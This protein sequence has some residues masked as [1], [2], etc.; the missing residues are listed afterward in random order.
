M[1]VATLPTHP[2][3]IVSVDLNERI[4]CYPKQLR[5]LLETIAPY[6]DK[7]AYLN[8]DAG[9]DEDAVNVFVSD[10][11]RLWDICLDL[12][13]GDLISIS[14]ALGIEIMRSMYL[15]EIVEVLAMRQEDEVAPSA[16]EVPLAEAAM[17]SDYFKGFEAARKQ[18]IAL[19]PWKEHL[20]GN[21]LA[22][23]LSTPAQCVEVK[24]AL[25]R[26]MQPAGA[27]TGGFLCAK[28]KVLSDGCVAR[29]DLDHN[30]DGDHLDSVI[31]IQWGRS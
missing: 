17:A 19:D 20:S 28:W 1:E 23:L 4:A 26:A 14:K 18:A 11:S 6:T 7:D 25:I 21:P 31:D 30:H 13:E 3:Y 22:S 24:N 2:G 16:V 27:T 8:E 9:V 29:C 12:D 15:L 5:L 10:R